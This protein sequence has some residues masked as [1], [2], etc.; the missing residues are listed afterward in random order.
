MRKTSGA[1]LGLA[2]TARREQPARVTH[3][4]LYGAPVGV[5]EVAIGIAHHPLG[6]VIVV[7]D[8][9]VGR[10]RRFLP[11]DLSVSRRPGRVNGL[12]A[13]FRRGTEPTPARRPAARRAS[14]S[15]AR[16]C[17]GF[18]RALTRPPS[19]CRTRSARPRPERPRT[20][21]TSA[22]PS[23]ASPPGARHQDRG[24]TGAGCAGSCRT[25][26]PPPPSRR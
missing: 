20:T 8:G 13:P 11:H 14:E 2:V 5:G 18:R 21:Y 24:R 15:A 25:P 6:A 7:L 22:A 3:E 4:L 12:R 17:A 10:H 1:V 16:R 26:G 23:G 9:D 19:A